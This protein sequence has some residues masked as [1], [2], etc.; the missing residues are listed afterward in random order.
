MLEQGIIDNIKSV[1]DW[2]RTWIA[3]KDFG[4]IDEFYSADGTQVGR[5]LC[6]VLRLEVKIDNA[7]YHAG[8]LIS[9]PEFELEAVL[10]R[11]SANS[12][13]KRR[14]TTR[15]LNAEDINLLIHSATWCQINPEL[16]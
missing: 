15:E 12:S 11:L 5:L 6:R 9:I 13:F 3:F 7:D 4:T 14:L 1:F 10:D 2:Y 16:E 8:Q